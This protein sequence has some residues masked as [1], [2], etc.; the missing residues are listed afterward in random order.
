[1]RRISWYCLPPVRPP[2][3]R[4]SDWELITP[5]SQL[6][7]VLTSF[8]RSH[9]LLSKNQLEKVGWWWVVVHGIDGI[10][11]TNRTDFAKTFL[12]GDW[13]GELVG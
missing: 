13:F 12:G 4:P 7:G 6:S 2:T 10:L 9:C 3:S 11:A 5:H 8:P 1:M